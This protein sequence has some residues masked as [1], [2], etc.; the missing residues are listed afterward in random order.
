MALSP[1]AAEMVSDPGVAVYG[2]A[3]VAYGKCMDYL[4]WWRWEGWS[5]G[6][7]DTCV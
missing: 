5:G 1:H 6:Y 3:A 7:T 4:E 2:E